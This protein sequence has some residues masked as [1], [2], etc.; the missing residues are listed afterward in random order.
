MYG[1]WPND[2]QRPALRLLP[3]WGARYEPC[4]W[5]GAMDVKGLDGGLSIS[6]GLW[7]GQGGAVAVP[8]WAG[9]SSAVLWW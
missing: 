4:D 7:P 6:G 2:N 5:A 8:Y 9:G 3:Y 1:R